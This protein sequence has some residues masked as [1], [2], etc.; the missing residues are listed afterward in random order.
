MPQQFPLLVTILL[1]TLGL[2][3]FLLYYCWRH[4]TKR[5]ATSLSA[6]ILGITLWVLSD[7]TQ[8]LLGGQP[9]A[10]YGLPLRYFAT[11]ITVVGVLLL[12]LEYTGRTKFLNGWA[13]AVLLAHP[14][15]M[16]AL[17]LSPYSGLIATTTPNPDVPWGYELHPEIGHVVHVLYCYALVLL[18]VSLLF[19]MMLRTEHGY[20]R[21]LLA[22]VLVVVTPFSV[23]ILYNVGALPFDLTPPT[24]AVTASLLAYAVFNLRI[25]DTIPVARQRVFDELSDL[26]VILDDE[27]RIIDANAA[28]IDAFD[29]ENDPLGTVADDAL[30]FSLTDAR[31]AQTAGEEVAATIDSTIRYLDVNVSVLSD[32]EDNV[33]ARCIVCRDVTDSR[34]RQR[35]LAQREQDLNLL[36]NVQSR[37]LRHNIRTDMNLIQGYAEQLVEAPPEEQREYYQRLLETTD[38]VIEQSTKARIIEGIIEEPTRIELELIGEL[39]SILRRVKRTHPDVR[40]ETTLPEETRVLA[41][42]QIGRALENLLDNAARHN[43]AADPRVDIAVVVLDE[44]VVLQIQ[45]NGAGIDPQEI[46]VLDE[47]EETPLQHGSGFGLWVVDWLVQ[48]SHGDL[49]F[50]VD[51]AGTTVTI[52]LESALAPESGP[53]SDSGSD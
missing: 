28:A 14:F 27:N 30:P 13:I 10:L 18:S 17:L 22:L 33:L 24:F 36:K 37:F 42:P 49:E 2:S 3:V 34:R 40:F 1:A 8:I 4:R 7:L 48:K 11:G 52:R 6:L 47:R 46:A 15:V 53:G 25:M 9:L 32:Y 41:T 38:G 51:G 50:E 31:G 23:S 26:V 16:M 43:T 19:N 39:T 20:R 5:G 21:Q 45:D 12:G 44:T 35:R 29:L